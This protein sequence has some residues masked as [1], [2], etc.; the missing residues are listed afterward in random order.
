MSKSKDITSSNR[1]KE[2]E[3]ALQTPTQNATLSAEQL[4]A[5]RSSYAQLG[6]SPPV[7]NI[8][9]RP[10]SRMSSAQHP[11]PSVTKSGSVSSD[12]IFF[13]ALGLN[14]LLNQGTPAF[15]MSPPTSHTPVFGQ[16]FATPKSFSARRVS[17]GIK[18]SENDEM[19]VEDV[20]DE[21]KLNILRKHLVTN[22]S[23]N[24][25]DNH[26]HAIGDSG[27]PTP[28]NEDGP[29]QTKSYHGL[30]GGEVVHDLYR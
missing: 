28:H 29:G 9:V 18:D 12:L 19:T 30:L 10:S 20:T 23:E 14:Q 3:Q 24:E 1:I 15:G 16:S 8:P 2:E 11:G 25:E 21:Q 26:E 7:P 13:K 4:A 17:R 5:R 22:D 6:H 27:P